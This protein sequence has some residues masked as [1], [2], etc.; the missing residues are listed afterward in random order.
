MKRDA[1]NL[2][3]LIMDP[4]WDEAE[5]VKGYL[6]QINAF[7]AS[8]N[9]FLEPDSALE[10]LN[11]KQPDLVLL[12]HQFSDENAIPFAREIRVNNYSLPIV[13]LTDNGNEAV[14]AKYFRIGVDDYRVKS[15]LDRDSL[16]TSIKYAITQRKNKVER[17]RAAKFDE[18]TNLYNRRF[19]FKRIHEEMTSSVRHNH[20]FS[21]CL[22]DLDG[23]KEINDR[24][25]HLSG[26]FLLRRVSDLN[27]ESVR[28]DDI[29]GRYGGDEF[30]LGLRKT[31]S[32]GA[33]RAAQK[34]TDEIG[35]TVFNP[36]ASEQITVNCSIGVAEFHGDQYDHDDEIETVEEFIDRA[37]QALYL[38]KEDGPGSVERRR[39]ERHDLDE[40]VPVT[41]RLERDEASA[42][43]VDV[44]RSGVRLEEGPKLQQGRS[45][46]L[47]FNS[48]NG[49]HVEKK[50]VIRSCQMKENGSHATLGVEVELPKMLVDEAVEKASNTSFFDRSDAPDLQ[51]S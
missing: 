16:H 6:R 33:Y 9:H 44:S 39:H 14:A 51:E 1:E 20:P 23:F 17:K 32:S 46:T 41:L 8:I 42:R 3:V 34:L 26:D 36:P 35:N 12:E 19:S 27:Q 13:V 11:H 28:T 30:L 21:L 31:S 5:E 43:V 50:G 18:L 40:P 47:L 25:G 37:D 7:N 29:V 22:I 38:A 49:R 2:S 10:S 48:D 15:E 24:L 45:I 4:S